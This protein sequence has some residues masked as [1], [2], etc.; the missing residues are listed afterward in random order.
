MNTLVAGL[1]QSGTAAAALLVRESRPF[2]TFDDRM[3]PDQAQSAVN[4]AAQ[5]HFTD[6]STLDWSRYDRVVVSPGLS[7]HHPLIVAAQAAE[8]PIL[9]EL[10]LAFRHQKGTVVAVTGSNGKSTTVSLIDHLL[11]ENGLK[12]RLCGNIGV[13]FARVVDEDPEA[14]YV[15]EVSS[16]Q[17]EHVDRFR[18][19][20]GVLL[21]VAA[22]HLDRHGTL[23]RYR[24][25][26]LKLFARQLPDDLALISADLDVSVPGAARRE[27]LPH[28]NAC[29]R[30]RKL[31]LADDWQADAGAN[32]TLIGH[33]LTN[34]LFACRVARELGVDG[35]GATRALTSFKGLVHRMER[36]GEHEGRI[37][38]NDSKATNVHAAQA[39]VDSMGQ[40]YVLILGGSDKG[41]RFDG[42]N[43]AQNQP[44]YIVAYGE[45]TNKICDDLAVYSPIREH[46]FDAACLRAHAVAEPGT[47]VL[48]APACA[49]FD[50][51][52]NF[53]A[54]GDR[55]KELFHELTRTPPAGA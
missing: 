41:G 23:A 12:S 5:D 53:A 9:S 38:I 50:Q 45:T 55:F 15:V 34:A 43:L 36:V 49:S 2:D 22:D 1:G 46:D 47:A 33:N 21:N 39:A 20:I 42:L 17:L 27:S 4:G 8:V 13:A 25:T 24:D 35:D 11:R 28:A 40:P 26:K 19:R 54:R 10:E 31:Y 29:M 7:I 52:P 18:P 30:D 14:V 44:Q 48:L 6:V 16:F 51:F 37:W 32:P 3:R